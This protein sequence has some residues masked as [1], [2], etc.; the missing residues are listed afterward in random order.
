MALA[1]TILAFLFGTLLVTAVGLRLGASRAEVIDRRLREAVGDPAAP[2]VELQPSFDAII[3]ALKRVGNKVP[4]SPSEM[5][6][7][8]L[9]LV[10]PAQLLERE[11]VVVA[12]PGALGQQGDPY[13]AAIRP[14]GTSGS[15]GWQGFSPGDLRA[16]IKNICEI[17]ETT[18]VQTIII[19]HHLLRDSKWKEEIKEVLARAEK[20]GKKVVTAAGFLGKDE[21][22]LEAHRRQLYAWNPD[23]PEER[24]R[25]SKN[26]QLVKELQ[27]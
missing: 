6:K 5:G 3:G 4:R 2:A 25:R 23:I 9:R 7:L 22:I 26:F 14:G 11:R 19:D 1:L 13:G 27:K 24:I 8:R 16:S 15:S 18:R 12:N 17:I 20:T 21:E 10:A